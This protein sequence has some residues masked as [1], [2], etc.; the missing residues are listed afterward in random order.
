MKPTLQYGGG[1]GQCHK[2][3]GGHRREQGNGEHLEGQTHVVFHSCQD[4]QTDADRQA[5][6]AVDALDFF[7]GAGLCIGAC[8]IVHIALTPQK[9]GLPVKVVRFLDD[10]AQAGGLAEG[11]QLGDLCRP[12]VIPGKQG[13]GHLQRETGAAGDPKL[14]QAIAGIDAAGN[15]GDRQKGIDGKA[16]MEQFSQTV[17]NLVAAQKGRE[18]HGQHLGEDDKPQPVFRHHIHG[19]HGCGAD[20][21]SNDQQI[22][23]NGDLQFE[24]TLIGQLI[25]PLFGTGDELPL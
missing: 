6:Q 2:E 8:E 19:E 24:N 11:V 23:H 10:A 9:C 18:K 1:P 3:A 7:R 13:E 15:Q 25:V 12:A 22:Q 20:A 17:Q 4:G 5:Q 16:A 21:E 14:L